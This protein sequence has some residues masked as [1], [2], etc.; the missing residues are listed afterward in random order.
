MEYLSY[1]QIEVPES[2]CKKVDSDYTLSSQRKGFQR[3]TTEET[4][5]FLVKRTK[6]EEREAEVL[7]E[8]NRKVFLKF[9]SHKKIWDSIIFLVSKTDALMSMYLYSSNLGDGSCFPQFIGGKIENPT[10]SFK[11]GMLLFAQCLKTNQKVSTLGQKSHF[12]NIIF[13]QNSH[14]ENQFFCAKFTL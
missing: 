10:L 5:A 12:E 13:S 11:Q 7:S 14:F 4:K 1:L 3:F 8:V 6:I 2:S 9:S